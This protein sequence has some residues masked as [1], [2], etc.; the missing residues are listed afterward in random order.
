MANGSR[1][2]VGL[3]VG[4]AQV[5]LDAESLDDAL[6]VAD[7]RMYDDKFATRARIAT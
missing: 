4:A 6:R 7:Q 1:S 5:S 3:S 2:G